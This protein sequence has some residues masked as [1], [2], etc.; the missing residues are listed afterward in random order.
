MI[1]LVYTT[2][3]MNLRLCILALCSISLSIQV[4]AQTGSYKIFFE[5]VYLHTDREQYASGEDIWFNAYLVNAQTNQLFNSSNNLYIELINP[6]ANIADRK[7]IRLDNGLGNGDFKLGDSIVSGTYRIRA[8]TNWMRN[9]G[10]NFVFEKEIQVYGDTIRNLYTEGVQKGPKP[11]IRVQE[12]IPATHITSPASPSILFFPEGGSM[13][14]NVPGVIAFKTQDSAGKGI[15]AKGILNTNTGSLLTEFSSDTTGMGTFLLTPAAGQ[16][17]IATGTLSNGKAFS[18]VL[19][20]ALL[21]G[22]SMNVRNTDSIIKITIS[23]NQTTLD[24]FKENELLLIFKN[25][26]KAYSTTSI[27]LNETQ[28][29]LSLSKK[30]FPSGVS[31]VTLYD[32][33]GKPQAERL[34]YHEGIDK[35]VLSISTDKTTYSSK[36]KTTLTIKTTDQN[37]LPVK[38]NLS[39]AVTDASIVTKNYSNILSYLNL[40]SDVRGKIENP[41]QYFEEHNPTRKQQLDLLLM[42]QGWRDFVWKRLA[43]SALRITHIAEQGITISGGLKQV[44]GNKY[45][46]NASLTLTAWGAKGSKIFSTTTDSSGKF[47]FDGIQLH[48]NQ[49]LTIT[50]RD[51]KGKKTGFI[52]VD[53]ST[54]IMYPLNKIVKSDT[55]AHSFTFANEAKNRLTLSNKVSIADTL[56]LNTVTIIGDKR[57]GRTISDTTFI[58]KREDY[59]LKYLKD[60]MLE[61]FPGAERLLE[62]PE[63]VIFYGLIPPTGEWGPRI[64]MFSIL[65]PTAKR[66]HIRDYS[67]NN[68]NYDFFNIPMDQIVSAQLIHNRSRDGIVHSFDGYF[69]DYFDI[70]LTVRPGAFERQGYQKLSLNIDGYYE[71][72]TFYAPK[73]EITNTK[74][75]LRTTI[76]WEPNITTDENGEATISYY[77]ADPKNKIRIVVEGITE[78]GIPVAGNRIYDVK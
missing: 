38:A 75:D 39:L 37:N 66:L 58:I 59:K 48:G 15:A 76:H 30:D 2:I 67:F 22:F 51:S 5:K 26:G 43:D 32:P 33:S 6:D 23:T 14:E 36:G 12:N 4:R 56:K 41:D 1:I 49:I 50:S 11:K 34:F 54:V 63:I 16:K 17:Q 27:R 7:I 77:N 62:A 3:N 25:K 57:H 65:P 45:I 52:K 44:W 73:Y 18:T 69:G 13:I 9:F 10:D 31:S 46:A 40:Q 35:A 71:A 64:P 24:E 74:P 61:K 29:M 55:L 8:Y 60:Y 70:F 68:R 28:L 72:R 19:P 21:K 78:D 53:T 47:F 42:T 20:T